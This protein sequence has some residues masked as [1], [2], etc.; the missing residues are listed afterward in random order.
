MNPHI[1]DDQRQHYLCEWFNDSII[2]HLFIHNQ[3][4]SKRFIFEI[5]DWFMFVRVLHLRISLNEQFN[6]FN[7]KTNK[8]GSKRH[9]YHHF[10][11]PDNMI[12]SFLNAAFFWLDC[13]ILGGY[14]MCK[15]LQNVRL[16]VK[17]HLAYVHTGTK[18]EKR[19]G[20]YT[21]YTILNS[22]RWWLDE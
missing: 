2:K 18:M 22:T 7:G 5:C 4:K 10:I 17:T 19:T 12:M 15:T 11:W 20:H 16:M 14:V 1:L 9:L 13:C 3:N 8:K 6:G 21:T